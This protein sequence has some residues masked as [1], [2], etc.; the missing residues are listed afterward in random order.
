M[1]DNMVYVVPSFTEVSLTDNTAVPPQI[2]HGSL[3]L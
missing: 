1:W 3:V 2:A